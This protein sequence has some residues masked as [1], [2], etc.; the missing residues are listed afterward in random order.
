M[1]RLYR[2]TSGSEFLRMA[3]LGILFAATMLAAVVVPRQV[4]MALQS[5]RAADVSPV[6]QIV[7]TSSKATASRRHKPRSV[8]ELTQA[9]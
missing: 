5:T 3:T 8:S 7:R 9:R 1:T 6:T 2:R 4:Q